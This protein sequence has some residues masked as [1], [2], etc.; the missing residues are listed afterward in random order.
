MEKISG[1]EVL[2]IMFKELDIEYCT[3]YDINMWRKDYNE[4]FPNIYVDVTRD[5][6]LSIPD[7]MYYFDYQNNIFYKQYSLICPICEDKHFKYPE[8][9]KYKKLEKYYK[10][11][12]LYKM[13]NLKK[14]RE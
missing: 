10:L 1:W 8:N 7:W 3:F 9:D 6:M 11:D 4:R 5:V 2:N 12:K 13:S 14:E